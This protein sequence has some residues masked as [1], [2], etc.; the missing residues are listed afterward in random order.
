MRLW[1]W[2]KILS[3]FEVLIP[4]N[5]THITKVKIRVGDVIE[6]RADFEADG[7][8][9]GQVERIIKLCNAGFLVV[10]WIVRAGAQHSFFELLFY[11][12][13]RLFEEYRLNFSLCLVDHWRFVNRAHFVN[14]TEGTVRNDWIFG[15]AYMGCTREWD[16]LRRV[17]R[18]E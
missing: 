3:W 12:R 4:E 6:F 11:R 5:D 7:H 14:V 1:A 16:H 15:V 13:V 17:I 8:R 18:D 10:S 9:F 2:R